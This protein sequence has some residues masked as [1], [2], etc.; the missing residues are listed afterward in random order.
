MINVFEKEVLTISTLNHANILRFIGRDFTES[1][2]RL[3]MERADFSLHDYLQNPMRPV[4]EREEV[5]NLAFGIAAG[6]VHLHSLKMIHKDLKPGNILLRKYSDKLIPQIGD[7][8]M[9]GGTLSYLAPE[10][11]VQSRP[12]PTFSNDVYSFGIILWEI[13]MNMQPGRRALPYKELHTCSDDK[14]KKELF[15]QAVNGDGKRPCLKD[16]KTALMHG[17]D[18]TYSDCPDAGN[19]ITKFCDQFTDLVSRCWIADPAARP[20]F[21]DLDQTK[22]ETTV[23]CAIERLQ[24]LLREAKATAEYA[25]YVNLLKKR[26]TTVPLHALR[27]A[28]CVNVHELSINHIELYYEPDE[29][30]LCD[31]KSPKA[32]L[33]HTR[34][35]ASSAHPCL[36]GEPAISTEDT[37]FNLPNNTKI[38]LKDFAESLDKLSAYCAVESEAGYG[39]TTLLKYCAV[40]ACKNNSAVTQIGV[41]VRARDLWNAMA[42]EPEIASGNFPLTST[43]LIFATKCVVKEGLTRSELENEQTQ[44][45]IEKSTRSLQALL[46]KKLCQVCL[47]VD[48]V[49]EMGENLRPFLDSLLAVVENKDSKDHCYFNLRRVLLGMRPHV[50]TR[51]L[52]PENL[53]RFRK[54]FPIA[55]IHPMDKETAVSY[56]TNVASLQEREA[57]LARQRLAL[58]EAAIKATHRLRIMCE[59]IKGDA[60]TARHEIEQQKREAAAE[61]ATLPALTRSSSGHPDN[62]NNTKIKKTVAFMEGAGIPFTPLLTLLLFQ[63]KCKDPEKERCSGPISHEF[64]IY[65]ELARSFPEWDFILDLVGCLSCVLQ[66]AELD[67]KKKAEGLHDSLAS[68]LQVSK[69]QPDTT[70]EARDSL[71][72]LEVWLREA[73]P[74]LVSNDNLAKLMQQDGHMRLDI[75][76]LLARAAQLCDLFRV[77]PRREKDDDARDRRVMWAHD[78]FQEFFCARFLTKLDGKEPKYKLL[79]CSENNTTILRM[80][81]AEPQPQFHWRDGKFLLSEKWWKVY[82]YC[83]NQRGLQWLWDVLFGIEPDANVEKWTG[84]LFFAQ[85][86][87]KYRLTCEPLANALQ[88][89]SQKTDPYTELDAMTKEWLKRL[90]DRLQDVVT[91][92]KIPEDSGPNE[93]GFDGKS[94]QNPANFNLA[95]REAQEQERLAEDRSAQ[96]RFRMALRLV[97]LCLERAQVLPKPKKKPTKG[98]VT[99]LSIDAFCPDD[100]QNMSLYVMTAQDQ[101]PG[102]LCLKALDKRG[103]EACFVV[104]YSSRYKKIPYKY[105]ELNKNKALLDE[106]YKAWI[107]SRGKSCEYFGDPHLKSTSRT[108]KLKLKLVFTCISEPSKFKIFSV[109]PDQS[110]EKTLERYAKVVQIEREC[111]RFFI[112]ANDKLIEGSSTAKELGLIDGSQVRVQKE[113][114]D[115]HSLNS[116]GTS[117]QAVS[118]KTRPKKRSKTDPL[119]KHYDKPSILPKFGQDASGTHD[120]L[121]DDVAQHMQDGWNFEARNASASTDRDMSF[122]SQESLPTFNSQ[123]TR[124]T[125]AIHR[126]SRKPTQTLMESSTSEK[127]GNDT[128]LQASSEQTI[129]DNYD[130]IFETNMD[131]GDNFF[132]NRS[133]LTRVA[134]PPHEGRLIRV[135][136][137]PHE[138]RLTRVAS[139]PHEGR[140]TRVASPPHEGR[141]IRVAIKGE[142]CFSSY[143]KDG[144]SPD[145]KG[146]S[147]GR[148]NS[149]AIIH[150]RFSELPFGHPVVQKVLHHQRQPQQQINHEI[151]FPA[152]CEIHEVDHDCDNEHETSSLASRNVVDLVSDNDHCWSPSLPRNVSPVR[153]SSCPVVSLSP[154]LT[155]VRSSTASQA[156]LSSRKRK[157][158][159]ADRVEVDLTRCSS[160]EGD[161]SQSDMS[162]D[163]DLTEDQMPSHDSYEEVCRNYPGNCRFGSSCRFAHSDRKFDNSGVARTSF[164]IVKKASGLPV[165]KRTIL[166]E[167]ASGPLVKIERRRP[168][169]HTTYYKRAC[170]YGALCYQKNPAHFERFHHPP[171]CPNQ[172]LLDSFSTDHGNYACDVC[173]NDQPLGT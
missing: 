12:P 28:L 92:N 106:N 137:P 172:H 19:L 37:D 14:K 51:G 127:S 163:L 78:T 54:Q 132:R 159:P 48:A 34:G 118:S 115:T 158:A 52:A 30:R 145:I 18:A 147:A 72:Q 100:P 10:Q 1:E 70:F 6:M 169:P 165:N 168:A 109:S 41:F 166:V 17:K 122:D 152:K 84:A 149:R 114:A 43:A 146:N 108:G 71:S 42:R 3:V 60:E 160:D 96:K 87:E 16:L 130:D 150:N 2:P 91:K 82:E 89:A 56:L 124:G 148:S 24:E 133:R 142:N 120:K 39:K 161:E 65:E 8:G 164:M 66:T 57:E 81:S 153:S 103:K 104:L 162:C 117:A 126:R 53:N 134:S 123:S 59:L 4:L 36:N 38:S 97:W 125:F 107:E 50:V 45:Q 102:L 33:Q 131:F 58:E 121:C 83:A 144:D 157:I 119:F 138:G 167:K 135:A 105:V 85:L 9:G 35:W 143:E 73:L 136:S 112:T 69:S 129:D 40:Q 47:S 90:R 49:D 23:M 155:P 101:Y 67:T 5:V 61:L 88:D 25:F 68:S 141:L 76:K 154:S 95:Q 79:C 20:L 7:F 98:P 171:L 128:R 46:E 21:D 173:H 13:A 31:P 116:M 62:D 15:F 63:I 29:D 22:R 27:P 77:P 94:A 32:T 93:G 170:N 26:V 110:L 86:A 156:Q 64:D 139:P 11:L 80:G 99:E 44:K 113:N 74:L 75:P 55:S 111:L 151:R 140:L